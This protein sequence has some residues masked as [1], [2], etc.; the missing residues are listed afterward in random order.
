MFL[1]GIIFP[2]KRVLELARPAEELDTTFTLSRL[3][4]AITQLFFHDIYR[5]RV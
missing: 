4:A 2:R 5:Y 1:Y 3:V